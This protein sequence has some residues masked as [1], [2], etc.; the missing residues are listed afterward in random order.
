MSETFEHFSYC[1]RIFFSGSWLI[2]SLMS[3]TEA[4]LHCHHFHIGDLRIK[5]NSCHQSRMVGLS[6]FAFLRKSLCQQQAR[7]EHWRTSSWTSTRAGWG[8]TSPWTSSPL[9]PTWWPMLFST[10]VLRGAGQKSHQDDHF[11]QVHRFP[12]GTLPWATLPIC[13]CA[14]EWLFS[15]RSQYKVFSWPKASNS[16]SQNCLS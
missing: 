16:K 12:P 7:T 10:T 15:G 4:W 2:W 5:A 9:S 8:G 1:Q 11:D 13:W 14:L 6:A 3:T